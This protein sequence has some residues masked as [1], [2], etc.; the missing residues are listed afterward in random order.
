MNLKRLVILLALS[1]LPL[2][3]T[4]VNTPTHNLVSGL[5]SEK[6]PVKCDGAAGETAYL[7]R[8]QSKTGERVSY[9]R[10]GPLGAGPDGHTMIGYAVRIGTQEKPF[11][12]H[13]DSHHPGY[14]E[15]RAP[16]GFTLS[17]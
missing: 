7:D 9:Y 14:Q 6:K 15:N 10:V 11:L 17:N 13:M 1:L 4:N 5:G 16:K 2:A 3:C 8:L 12:I